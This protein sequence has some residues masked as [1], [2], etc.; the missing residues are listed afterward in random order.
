MNENIS[1]GL[2]LPED[3]DSNVWRIVGNIA[4]PRN[5]ETARRLIERTIRKY[6]GDLPSAVQDQA[7]AEVTG[8]F[9]FHEDK[10]W[11]KEE[12]QERVGH[13]IADGVKDALSSQP[14]IKNHETAFCAI[15]SIEPGLA[16]K[17][18][19]ESWSSEE[20]TV[21]VDYAFSALKSLCDKDAV[22]NPSRAMH[23]RIDNAR[24]SLNEE[25][26]EQRLERLWHLRDSDWWLYASVANI[27]ELLMKLNSDHFYTLV[28][29]I[30]HPVIHLR[31][32]RCVTD[33][34]AASDL[35]VPLQ[36]LDCRSADSM[37]A[38]ATVHVLES[39]NS[40]DSD[41]RWRRERDGE[42]GGIDPKASQLLS[43]LID[44]IEELEPV[45]CARWV[46]ELLDYGIFA[47]NAQSGSKRTPRVEQLEELC[48]LQLNRLVR[49]SW[50]EELS[51]TLRI[52]LCLNPLTPRILPL[53]Q[54][55]LEA[56]KDH[57]ARS[58]EIARL[59]LETHEQQIADTFRRGDGFYYHLESWTNQDWVCGL[60]IAL[61]LS[62][63]SI[64]LPEWVSQ[65]CRILPLSAWD[66]EE[67]YKCF[68]EADKLAQFRFLVALH[69]V[70]MYNDVGCPDDPAAVL[71]LAED[72][73]SHCRFVGRHIPWSLPGPSVAEYAARVAIALGRPSD[74]WLLEQAENTGVG[75]RT[76]WAMLDQ[77]TPDGTRRID[78]QDD[79]EAPIAGD[80]RRI[81]SG[82][83]GNVRGLD[84]TELSYLGYLWL[85][86]EAD[87]EAEDTAMAIVS[88]PERRLNRIHKIIALK[89][90]AFAASKRSLAPEAEKKAST[91][92]RQ[93][94]SSHSAMTEE[95][96]ERQ[97]ID[98]L[99]KAAPNYLS[100]PLSSDSKA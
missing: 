63:E 52:G 7:I 72:L 85:L 14:G 84:I 5:S 45:A 69:A 10:G 79:H 61:V 60:A 97:Q 67:D 58:T 42:Q 43:D 6:A 44:R 15:G 54:V 80:L 96:N 86:L 17:I 26:G 29:R 91:L 55:A 12:V 92:Y 32:A 68:L 98:E 78:L 49:Q 3:V 23:L 83:F 59:M 90:L 19:G 88:L 21:F 57:P 31:A 74:K 77:A 8:W 94:W 75:P 73:W 25:P 100:L 38:L 13:M 56:W 82:R 70:Q 48:R 99:L 51:T 4:S 2:P 16:M 28:D 24:A 76:L 64:D 39:V 93:L 89:L 22:I 95:L 9:D 27:V 66:A 30:E 53:A 46:C 81:A 1:L 50:S 35:D 40:L 65:N 87:H 34:F 41:L 62:Q 18:I 71:T 47:L 33:Q 37:V 36:W 11:L 20:L